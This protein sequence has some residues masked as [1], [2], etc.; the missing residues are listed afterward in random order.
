VI[1]GHKVE[2]VAEKHVGLVLGHAVDALGEA[3]VDVD[4][5][6]T[7]YSC[8]VSIDGNGVWQPEEETTTHDLFGSRGEWLEGSR[9]CSAVNLGCPFGLGCRDVWPRRGRSSHRA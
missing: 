8:K 4:R 1:L 5:L 9:Q 2:E 3:L 6:P 7:R